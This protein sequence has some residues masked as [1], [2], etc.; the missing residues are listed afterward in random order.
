VL[1]LCLPPSTPFALRARTTRTRMLSR[2]LRRP[3]NNYAEIVRIVL[4]VAL[5]TRHGTV[6]GVF[7]QMEPSTKSKKTAVRYASG[8]RGCTGTR[9]VRGF[10][11]AGEQ[12]S[13]PNGPSDGLKHQHLPLGRVQND[14]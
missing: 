6:P 13:L 1:G 5:L 3:N 11:A 14:L 7:G 10:P 4:F 12:L 2:D 9:C 8:Y